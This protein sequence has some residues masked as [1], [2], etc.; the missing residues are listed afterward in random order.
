MK[1]YYPFLLI[2]LLC[3]CA[4]IKKVDKEQVKKEIADAEKSFDA[5]AKEKGVAEAFWY[6]AADDAVI[7]RQNDT[8][9]KGK[10]NIRS[11]YSADRFKNAS[12][13]WSPDFVDVSKDGELGYTYGNYVW[14]S[15]DST[16]KVEEDKGVFHTVWKKQK[17]G[18]W[19][20]VWD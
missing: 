9:I 10:E 18:N 5:M 13:T 14:Q 11:F 17:D 12:V 2:I 8:L 4:D 1:R 16:G 6:F 20:Y 7:K 3:S 19:K 15:R